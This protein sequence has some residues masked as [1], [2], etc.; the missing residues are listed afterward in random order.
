MA[1]RPRRSPVSGQVSCAVGVVSGFTVAFTKH[2]KWLVRLLTTIPKFVRILL[3]SA[4]VLW[5]L[6]V[7]RLLGRRS[8]VVNRSPPLCPPAMV[9]LRPGVRTRKG[10]KSHEIYTT[11][12][13]SVDSV[14]EA[15]AS[16]S[17]CCLPLVAA[18]EQQSHNA[19]EIALISPAAVATTGRR[20][21]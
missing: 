5:F 14:S 2:W 12:A 1:E 6:I 20:K 7:H 9:V 13:R 19:L 4:A 11:I 21:P 3:T 8:D 16:V 15:P 10:V 18:S 17:E